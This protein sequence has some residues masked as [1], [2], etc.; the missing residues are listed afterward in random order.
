MVWWLAYKCTQNIR[1]TF[2]LKTHGLKNWGGGTCLA[3]V[4]W[5]Y[6]TQNICGILW[7]YGIC[8]TANQN[9]FRFVELNPPRRDP[10]A[11]E[12]MWEER[13]A[14]PSHPLPPLELPLLSPSGPVSLSLLCPQRAA[15]LTAASSECRGELEAA[16][17]RTLRSCSYL[18]EKK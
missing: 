2:P 14:G 1:I 17:V 10:E 9:T 4:F 5:F 15:G 11:P 12:G 13:W 6:R 18:D 16:V 3:S 8:Q 7:S